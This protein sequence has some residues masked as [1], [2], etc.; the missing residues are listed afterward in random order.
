MD[1]ARFPEY[2]QSSD[3]RVHMMDIFGIL[4]VFPPNLLS[5]SK[6]YFCALLRLHFVLSNQ[7]IPFLILNIVS[8]NIADGQKVYLQL[9]ISI[10]PIFKAK[11]PPGLLS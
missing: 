3:C 9:N 1:F 11:I 2:S 7:M 10:P 4:S 8:V 5:A 6:I